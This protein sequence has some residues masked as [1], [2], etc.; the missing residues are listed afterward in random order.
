MHFQGCPP[1]YYA[2]VLLISC[3]LGDTFC[4]GF[5]VENLPLFFQRSYLLL[6]VVLCILQFARF[7]SG[8]LDHLCQLCLFIATF[9]FYFLNYGTSPE[10]KT[11]SFGPDIC[12]LVNFEEKL[13]CRCMIF[14]VLF[15]GQ[16]HPF[17]TIISDEFSVLLG[18][19]LIVGLFSG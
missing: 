19:G 4:H 6:L 2:S 7:K 16:K 12:I 3:E 10:V 17:Q 14:T 5:P 11:A 8:L 18:L 9:I 1:L 15:E 13:P